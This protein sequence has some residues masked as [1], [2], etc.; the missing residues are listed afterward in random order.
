MRHSVGGGAATATA[1][2]LRP[3]ALGASRCDGGPVGA[4]VGG[5]GVRTHQPPSQKHSPQGKRCQGPAAGR[6]QYA[7]LENRQAP[8]RAARLP[9]GRT[10]ALPLLFHNRPC[11]PGQ[12]LQFL[13]VSRVRLWRLRLAGRGR[14]FAVQISFLR[15]H[16]RATGISSGVRTAAGRVYYLYQPCPTWPCT[17]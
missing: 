8:R 14:Y 16:S 17:S 1:P 5:G 4:S 13:I 2:G 7:Y 9:Q 3:P 11:Y 10:L 15:L 12:P 6:R